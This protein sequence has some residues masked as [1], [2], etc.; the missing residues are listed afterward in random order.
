M[1]SCSADESHRIF[2]LRHH[3]FHVDS[4]KAVLATFNAAHLCLDGDIH[5]ASSVDN[6]LTN[7]DIR[8]LVLC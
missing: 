3:T 2:G 6:A 4:G 8:F 5:R 7:L 1:Y